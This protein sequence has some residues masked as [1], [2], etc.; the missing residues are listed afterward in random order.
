MQL[1]YT[2]GSP[3]IEESLGKG[4]VH[5]QKDCPFI[6]GQCLYQDTFYYFLYC[7]FNFLDR[8]KPHRHNIG[9]TPTLLE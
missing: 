6:C 2:L 7:T 1:E 5:R 8:I 9:H 4:I 3:N